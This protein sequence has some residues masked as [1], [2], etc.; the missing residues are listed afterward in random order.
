MLKEYPSMH[1]SPSAKGGR[2]NGSRH[3]KSLNTSLVV[4]KLIKQRLQWPTLQGIHYR[5]SLRK[6][7]NKQTAATTMTKMTIAT[8]PGG[9]VV[10]VRIWFPEVPNYVVKNVQFS[11]KPHHTFKE[12][13]VYGS[14]TGKKAVSSNCPW[15]GLCWNLDKTFKSANIIGKI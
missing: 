3:L 8:K 4:T 6:I 5:I 13:D 14:C 1:K 7:L 9:G 10:G 2:L 11:T 15:W 12:T